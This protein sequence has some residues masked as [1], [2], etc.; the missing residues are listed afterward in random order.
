MQA[1][2]A[3]GA[4]CFFLLWSCLKRNACRPLVPYGKDPIGVMVGINR[5]LAARGFM[6]RAHE[7]VFIVAPPLIITAS[8]IREDLVKP[9]EVLAEVD[10]TL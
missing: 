3:F 2:A 4:P 7:N 9:D 6:T 10:A 5:K 8:Q 1:S